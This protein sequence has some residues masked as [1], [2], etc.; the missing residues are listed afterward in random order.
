MSGTRRP[1]SILIVD[2]EPDIVEIVSERALEIV[3]TIYPA[4]DTQSA[5]EIA[6]LHNVDVAIL[7]IKMPSM[8]GLE[9]FKTLKTINPDIV[10]VFLTGYADREVILEAMRLR[11]YEFLVKPINKEILLATIH[12][13][14]DYADLLKQHKLVLEALLYEY[15]RLSTREFDE[16]DHQAQA[17]VLQKVYSLMQMKMA[18]R[19][20]VAK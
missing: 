2:D 14:C 20:A 10:G 19:Q 11:A 18:N 15:T 17:A 7:D 3:D 1:N 4:Y 12:H 5:I 16:L 13:S 6:R 9:C 8:S